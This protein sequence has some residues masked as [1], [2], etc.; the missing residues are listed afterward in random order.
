MS[1]VVDRSLKYGGGPENC[2]ENLALV[3]RTVARLEAIPAGTGGIEREKIRLE[4]TEMF[5]KF[6]PMWE[7]LRE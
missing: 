1:D 2:R 5:R 4:L 6:I 7:R 3:S